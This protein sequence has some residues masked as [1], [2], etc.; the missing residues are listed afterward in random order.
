MLLLLLLLL[1]LLLLLLLLLG[2]MPDFG[3]GLLLLLPPLAVMMV[4][5]WLYGR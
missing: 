3:W 4:S 2:K 1:M 5:S